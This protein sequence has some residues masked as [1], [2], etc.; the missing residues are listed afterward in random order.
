MI[1]VVSLSLSISLS[2]SL[3]LLAHRC[4]CSEWQ[5]EVY[6]QGWWS[7]LLNKDSRHKPKSQLKTESTRIANARSTIAKARRV[8]NVAYFAWADVEY[9]S[10]RACCGPTGCSSSMAPAVL[11]QMACWISSASN[12]ASY[13]YAKSSM[14]MQPTCP[15]TLPDQALYAKCKITTATPDRALCAKC[16]SIIATC[17][18][19]PRPA[20]RLAFRVFSF[21]FLNRRALESRVSSGSQHGDVQCRIGVIFIIGVVFFRCTRRCL[22]A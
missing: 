17:R 22:A 6:H 2:L 16:K 20:P 13:L 5:V 10:S 11:F 18:V 7:T 12:A 15:L 3:S 9:A 19:Y 8:A 1:V 4:V 14:D 21:F